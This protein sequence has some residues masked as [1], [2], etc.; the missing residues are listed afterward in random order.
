LTGFLGSKRIVLYDTIEKQM[1]TEEIVAVLAHEIGHWKHSHIIKTVA[2]EQIYSF[3]MWYVAGKFLTSS[4]AYTAL[5]FD[6]PNVRP[7]MVG[8]M[9]FIMLY[10]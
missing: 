2:I 8:L 4:V 3:F 7:V 9:T 5:G 6:D 10:T 1:S